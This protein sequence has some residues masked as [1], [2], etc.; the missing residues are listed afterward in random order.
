M[1]SSVRVTPDPTPPPSARLV[2]RMGGLLTGNEPLRLFTTLG[3]HRRLSRWWLPFA[4]TL[5]LRGRL[6]RPD[7]EVVVLRV[8]WNCHCWYEWVQHAQL[9]RRA[10]VTEAEVAASADGPAHGC[11]TPRRRLLLEVVDELQA[12]KV[13]SDRLWG[14][15]SSELATEEI[16]ELCFLVGHYEM[17]A[18]ALNSLGVEPEPTALGKLEP[19]CSE[20]ADRLRHEL[21]RTRAGS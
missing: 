15:V 12:T 8:A 11:W 4:G 13:M 5:L 18:M 14:R 16:I 20:L 6:P 19:G 2:A 9:A 17:L 10:G 1:T 3:R 7:S 21:V